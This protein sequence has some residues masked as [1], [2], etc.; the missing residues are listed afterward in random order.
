MSVII[1]QESASSAPY[2]EIIST[3]KVKNEDGILY[4][5]I[6]FGN[7][8]QQRITR[9]Q[10]EHAHEISRLIRMYISIQQKMLQREQPA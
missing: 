4:L 8:L 6:K 9:I 7:L 10:T 5:D 3:R 2:S 1:L